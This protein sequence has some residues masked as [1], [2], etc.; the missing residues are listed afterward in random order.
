MSTPGHAQ[1][2]VQVAGG[3]GFVI[4]GKSRCHVITAAHCLPHLPQPHPGVYSEERTYQN[5]LGSLHAAELNVWAECLFVDLIGDLA[6]LG[7]PD[8]QELYEQAEAYEELV[9]APTPISIR[10]MRE[11][12]KGWMLALGADVWFPP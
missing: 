5:L 1:A 3:R 2:V 8:D 7:P 11:N 12:E 10:S 4:Q 6:I 9:E